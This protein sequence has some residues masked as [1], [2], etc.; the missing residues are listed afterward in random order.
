MDPSSRYSKKR[1][2]GYGADSV[3]YELEHEGKEYLSRLRRKPPLSIALKQ[4]IEE[5]EDSLFDLKTRL[6]REVKVHTEM[7]GHPNIPILYGVEMEPAVIGSRIYMELGPS[8]VGDYACQ[9]GHD[10]F[11]DRL[12]ASYMWQ[13]LT[14]LKNM[15]DKNILHGDVKPGN[16]LIYS[17]GRLKLCDFNRSLPN[18]DPKKPKYD[19]VG[20]M[21]WSAPEILLDYPLFDLSVDVWSAGLVMLFML[22]GIQYVRPDGNCSETECRCNESILVQYAQQFGKPNQALL[23]KWGC[24]D[25]IS[26]GVRHKRARKSWTPLL[27]SDTKTFDA[28]TQNFL[29][30]IFRWDPSDRA[31]SDQLLSHRYFNR[32]LQH[33]KVAPLVPPEGLHL[34][35]EPHCHPTS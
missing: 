19:P 29:S 20:T 10:F 24:S 17:D 33:K 32:L 16:L 18:F 15:H 35:R 28:D 12:V 6:D 34:E 21:C 1:K 30:R 13:L 3:V 27:T 4:I 25:N 26:K 2:I 22:F 8:T 11:P 5:D 23:V 9:T 31:T 7:N 14:A